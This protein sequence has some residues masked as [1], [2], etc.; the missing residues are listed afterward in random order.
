MTDRL[1]DKNSV[2][3]VTVQ[4]FGATYMEGVKNEGTRR[5]CKLV[6]SRI[7]AFTKGRDLYFDDI[8]LDW[9]ERFDRWMDNNNMSINGKSVYMRTLRWLFGQSG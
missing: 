7:D 4:E 5:G 6:L 1:S 9:L 8:T 2:S 3:S